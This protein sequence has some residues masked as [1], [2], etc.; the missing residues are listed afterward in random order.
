[1]SPYSGYT[2]QLRSSVYQP[3]ELALISKAST[4]VSRL[5]GGAV[6]FARI[7]PKSIVQYENQIKSRYLKVTQICC[8]YLF[9]IFNALTL[10]YITIINE[11]KY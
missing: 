9:C 2:G 8:G 7:L 1:M 11:I 6:V 4:N 5:S 10:I 3:T